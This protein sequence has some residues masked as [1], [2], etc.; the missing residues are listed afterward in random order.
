MKWKIDSSKFK[1]KAKYSPFDGMEIK[2]KVMMTFV[3]GKMYEFGADF[4]S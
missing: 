3:N 1:S 2:G 4:Y